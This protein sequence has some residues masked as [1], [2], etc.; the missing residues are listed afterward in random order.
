MKLDVALQGFGNRRPYLHFVEQMSESCGT[1][2]GH[3]VDAD[4]C[5]DFGI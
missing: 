1:D 2:G 4:D 5:S 3:A